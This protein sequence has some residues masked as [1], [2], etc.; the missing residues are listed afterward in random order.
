MDYSVQQKRSI[1]NR[2]FISRFFTSVLVMIVVAYAGLTVQTAVFA[3][4]RKELREEI[5]QTQIAI[6][7]LEVNYFDLAQAIDTET[8]NSLGFTEIATPL[9]AYTETSYPSVALR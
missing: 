6:S 2:V 9:F 1:F 7:D 4:E 5:R 3:N 8:I